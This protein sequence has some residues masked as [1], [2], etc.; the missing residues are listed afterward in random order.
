MHSILLSTIVCSRRV[1]GAVPMGERQF[2]CTSCFKSFPRSQA[3]T[4]SF[5][6]RTGHSSDSTYTGSS[7]KRQTLTGARG[8]YNTYWSGRS[9]GRVYFK[10]IHILLCSQCYEQRKSANFLIY[11]VPIGVVSGALLLW[12]V[13]SSIG[14]AIT[15]SYGPARNAESVSA[16]TQK[17]PTDQNEILTEDVP[18]L[19]VQ[20]S[21]AV[22][23][24]ASEENETPVVIPSQPGLPLPTAEPFLAK[25]IRESLNSGG[26][27][28]WHASISEAFGYV[29]ASRRSRYVG[30]QLCRTFN[31]S[32]TINGE[33]YKSREIEACRDGRAGWVYNAE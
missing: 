5:D 19:K 10:R 9:S 22:P 26:L 7:S 29:S 4:W 33:R 15:S 23:A 3:R 30:G 1:F 21:G 25:A 13:I 27:V 31:Y 18:Q 28:R 2:E 16:A 14:N 20:D 6:Q 32:A 24:E 11:A 8:P 12:L 17:T